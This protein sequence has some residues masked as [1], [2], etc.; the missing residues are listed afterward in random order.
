MVGGEF[1]VKSRRLTAHRKGRLLH[2]AAAAAEEAAAAAAA[3]RQAAGESPDAEG[4]G[5][6][7]VQQAG[8]VEPVADLSAQKREEL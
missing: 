8:T 7:V 3:K 1:A 5:T 4:D 6:G 2:P